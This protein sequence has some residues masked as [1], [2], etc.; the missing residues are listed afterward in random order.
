M[1]VEI[2][3]EGRGVYR[4]F[5]GRIAARDVAESLEEILGDPRADQLQFSIADYSE[6]SKYDFVQSEADLVAAYMHSAPL[7]IPPVLC[8]I[9]VTDPTVK[10]RVQSI[11]ASSE[12]TFPIEYFASVTCARQWIARNRSS[13]TEAGRRA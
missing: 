8:A 10:S 3:W 12:T 5:A 9:V 4:R 11:L 6:V 2:V 13:A 1:A 7:S